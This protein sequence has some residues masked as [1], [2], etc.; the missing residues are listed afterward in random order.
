MYMEL[1]AL[2]TVVF[3]FLHYA[4]VMKFLFIIATVKKPKGSMV[5]V[6]GY[7]TWFITPPD[8]DGE[9]GF[10]LIV[11]ILLFPLAALLIFPFIWLPLLIGSVIT[12][13]ILNTRERLFGKGA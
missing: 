8:M 4:L 12:V 6:F 11:N 2:F 9:V 5:T 10:L 7:P 1:G 13:L 3:L